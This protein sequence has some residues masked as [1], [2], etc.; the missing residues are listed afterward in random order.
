[1]A[2]F[3]SASDLDR[4]VAVRHPDPHTVLGP[5]SAEGGFV[6]RAFRPDVTALRVR[7]ASGRA[8]DMVRTHAAGL[9]E[10]AVTRAALGDLLAAEPGD[11]AAAARGES[12]T[13]PPAAYRLEPV[14]AGE[15]T[16]DPYAFWPTVGELD[17]HLAGEGR[18]YELYTRLGARHIEHQG[19]AGVAFAVCAPSAR[20][21]SVVGDFNGWDGRRHAMRRLGPGIWE[22]FVPDLG[23]GTLYKYEVWAIRGSC[24]SKPIPSVRPWSCAPTPPPA[25][26]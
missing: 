20:R 14:P 24:W 9:F 12:A 15:A 26:S 2:D 1:M 11:D 25:S 22:I 21:V 17:L 8:V 10:A 7:W 23:E 6:V 3:P 13:L 5:H 4:L 16:H 19:V 18:H